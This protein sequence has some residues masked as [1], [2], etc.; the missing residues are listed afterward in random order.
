MTKAKIRLSS[1]AVCIALLTGGV[2]SS[3]AIAQASQSPNEG[4]V[5]SGREGQN[6]TRLTI[7]NVFQKQL[8]LDS[9]D[10]DDPKNRVYASAKA[11][12]SCVVRRSKDKA[13]ELFGGPLTIDPR[14]QNLSSVLTRKYKNCLVSGADGVPMYVVNAALAEQ[15]L[16]AEKLEVG[17]KPV[18][19][20]FYLEDGK[21]TSLE[22]LS[23]CLSAHSP[24]ITQRY[25]ESDPGSD[26]EKAELINLYGST[27]Q[28]GV[29]SPVNLPEVEQRA[30][31][32]TSLY[33]W[34]HLN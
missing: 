28:C 24:E 21:I 15:I 16:N 25:L 30:L 34:L 27:P 7:S 29:N 20:D 14:Y 19:P 13:S 8:E 9:L 2:C 1:F 18:T 5:S 4:R 17:N 31:L 6:T 10:R 23:R 11:M 26:N 22:G 12:A 3:F 32:A 33:Q